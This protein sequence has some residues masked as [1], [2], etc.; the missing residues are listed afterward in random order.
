[1]F[2]TI[3][4]DS[5]G[6]AEAVSDLNGVERSPFAYDTIQTVNRFTRGGH[7]AAGDTP[8]HVILANADRIHAPA[9]EICP[10]AACS[11]FAHLI[12]P[13]S[14]VRRQEIVLSVRLPLLP[15][16]CWGI[17]IERE[18]IDIRRLPVAHIGWALKDDPDKQI[19]NDEQ[20]NAHAA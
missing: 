7:L 18:Q 1:L 20:Y 19:K 2:E 8:L 4:E 13:F 9:R 11:P 6:W 10:I 15:T 3:D 12:G 5:G 16:A 17:W 14:T